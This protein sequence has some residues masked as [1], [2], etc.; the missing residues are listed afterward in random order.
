M[1][2]VRGITAGERFIPRYKLI[3]EARIGAGQRLVTFF[4][5]HA[6][7]SRIYIYAHTLD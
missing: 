7:S 5:I 6:W 3:Q 1:P 2:R 4:F